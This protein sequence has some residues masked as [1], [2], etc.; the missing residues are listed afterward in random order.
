MNS[1]N[2]NPLTSVATRNVRIKSILIFLAAS[3]LSACLLA[4][5]GRWSL[6]R[7]PDSES[8]VHFDWS[9]WHGVLGGI[10][11]PGYPG[12]VHWVASSVGLEAI[13]MIHWLMMVIA[14]AVLCWGFRSI[15]FPLLTATFTSIPLLFARSLWDLGPSLASDSPAIAL[16]IVSIGIFLGVLARPQALSRWIALSIACMSTLLV[17]PAYLFLIPLLPLL[18]LWLMRFVFQ[19]TSRE[20]FLIS[21]SM[22]VVLLTPLFGYAMLR[23]ATIGEFGFVSFAGYNL[24]GITGQYL[25]PADISK[26]P[27]EV[28][29]LAHEIIA[30]R[31]DVDDYAPPDTYEAI[32]HLFNP[33]V[34]RMAD[35]AAEKVLGDDTALCNRRL[36]QLAIASLQ[37]HR[38]QYANWLLQNGRSMLDQLLRNACSDLSAKGSMLGVLF[39]LLITAV[40]PNSVRAWR[41]E[42]ES[43][44]TTGRVAASAPVSSTMCPSRQFHTIAWIAIGFIVAKG[45]LVILV[46]PALGRYVIAVGCLIPC[47][48]GWVCYQLAAILLRKP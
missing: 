11:T 39:A 15:G 19:R 48:I 25:E 16:A 3:I 1:R 43:T 7:E 33:T 41:D 22:G 18:A 34:W 44:G 29:E 17:R 12:I 13:P 27:E 45:L 38:T 32:V 4:S 23:R 36:R 10:R 24:I 26:L 31:S 14:T 21:L 40:S 42:R 37:L 8:Y 6:V 20:S 30:N 35:P 47:L 2:A 9:S 5:S 28:R 46:E